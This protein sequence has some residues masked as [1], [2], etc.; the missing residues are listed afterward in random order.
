M[1]RESGAS[2]KELS[3]EL[4]ELDERL[5]ALKTKATDADP[6]LKIGMQ[7]QI[8]EL[9]EKRGQAQDALEELSKAGSGEMPPVDHTAEEALTDLRT[10]LEVAETRF[11]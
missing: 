11:E 10:A 9:D 6:E 5:A 3:A 8:Y 1:P 4:Q 7:S 2:L